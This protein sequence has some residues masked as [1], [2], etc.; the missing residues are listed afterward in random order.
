MIK[1]K[2]LSFVF[3]LMFLFWSCQDKIEKGDSVF[4]IVIVPENLIIKPN[5]EITLY[6]RAYD[7]F[8]NRIYVENFSWLSSDETIAVVSAEGLVTGVSSGSIII[9]ASLSKIEGKRDLY[10]TTNRRRV[11]SE[12]FTS[13]T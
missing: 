4:K 8:D 1:F 5:Q 6:A 7:E 13:S 10:V 2:K 11:L 9:T 12:M 3:I